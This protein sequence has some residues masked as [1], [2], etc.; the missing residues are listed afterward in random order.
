MA[1]T[2]VPEIWYKAQRA[3]RTAIQFLIVAVPVFNL[4]LIAAVGYLEEQTDLV[5]PGWVFVVLN[6]TIALLAFLIGLVARLMAVPGVNNWFTKWLNAGSVPKSALTT[7]RDAPTGKVEA[8]LV[9]PD[10]KV[11]AVF[12]S[13]NN[14][15]G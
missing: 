2:K 15:P 5:V 6:A 11:H 13:G 8:V 1:E 9:Q 4:L 14:F 10:P 3:L 7:V 12:Q